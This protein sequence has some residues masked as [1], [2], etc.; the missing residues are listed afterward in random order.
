MFVTYSD[1]HGQTWAR[2]RDITSD[3]KKPNWGW[4]ATGPCHAI[5]LFEGPHRG[6]LVVPADHRVSA[7][8]GDKGPCGVQMILSDDHGKTWRLGLIDDNY[9]DT[10]ESN[11]TTIVELAGGQLYINTRDQNGKMPGTR[12]EAF[13]S[14]GG[15]SF[16]PTVSSEW[17]TFRPAAD[18]LDPPVVQ[19]SVWRMTDKGQRPIV[20][21][22]GPDEHGPSGGGRKDLRL[23]YSTDGART[24]KDGPLVHE[25]PA[26]YSDIAELRPGLGELGVLFEAGDKGEKSYSRIDFAVVTRT[27]IEKGGAQ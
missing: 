1:D 23:R 14:N 21:F 26:A 22:S 9:E 4:Y 10:L 7:T 13:S 8:G 5:Q 27:E 6:R 12:A 19:C 3:V 11:E 24:W 20:V 16:D 18:V 15:E 2:P 25:G 17:K